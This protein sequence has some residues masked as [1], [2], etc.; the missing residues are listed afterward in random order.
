MVGGR[1]EE[2]AEVFGGEVGEGR[3][4]AVWRERRGGG[5]G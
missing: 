2:I 1:V 5:C 3:R 4:S